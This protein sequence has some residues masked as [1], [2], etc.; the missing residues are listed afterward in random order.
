MLSVDSISMPHEPHNCHKDCNCHKI[1]MSHSILRKLLYLVH[2]GQLYLMESPWHNSVM[3]KIDFHFVEALNGKW[4]KWKL[5]I[6]LIIIMQNFIELVWTIQNYES[7]Y[8]CYWTVMTP[9]CYP[10]LTEGITQNITPCSRSPT[11]LL[12]D[13]VL[14][15]MYND[16][17]PNLCGRDLCHTWACTCAPYNTSL[18]HCD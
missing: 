13:F 8:Q 10:V 7:I 14:Y 9:K 17:L 11:F 15:I 12:N 18:C 4:W 3:L 16:N 1:A 2:K 5:I 6:F